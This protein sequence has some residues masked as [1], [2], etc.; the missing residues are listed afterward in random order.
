MG[1]LHSGEEKAKLRFVNVEH[2]SEGMSLIKDGLNE[3]ESI[4]LY[5]GDGITNGTKV[6]AE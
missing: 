2:Q 4:I 6:I 5:P 3:G 1:R